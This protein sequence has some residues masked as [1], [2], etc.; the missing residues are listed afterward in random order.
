MAKKK[1][2][3]KAPA[4]APTPAVNE[5]TSQQ[6]AD[7]VHK[8]LCTLTNAEAREQLIAAAKAEA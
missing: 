3:D 1:P 7:L 6:I 4:E 2:D 5:P 8:S